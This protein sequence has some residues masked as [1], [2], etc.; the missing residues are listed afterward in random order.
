[1]KKLLFL[2][3]L[4]AANTVHAKVE[5]VALD[6]DLGYWEANASKRYSG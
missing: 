3:F 6:I 4:I 2:C 5:M 1:M